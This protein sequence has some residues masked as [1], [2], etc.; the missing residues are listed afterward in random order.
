MR[1]RVTQPKRGRA[2]IEREL[3][4]PGAMLLHPPQPIPVCSLRIHLMSVWCQGPAMSKVS[5]LSSMS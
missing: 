5:S 2:V 4:R 3:W 1:G